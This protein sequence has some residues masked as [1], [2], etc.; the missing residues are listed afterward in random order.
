MKLNKVGLGSV[1][2]ALVSLVQN[3]NQLL[4]V[5]ANFFIPF[6]RSKISKRIQPLPFSF[7]KKYW[8]QPLFLT[9]PSLAIHESVYDEITVVKSA[10]SYLDHQRET[11]DQPIVLS[12]ND[13]SDLEEAARSTIE[14]KIA[15]Y[16]NYEPEKDNSDDRGEVKSLAHIATKGYLYFCSHDSNAIKLIEKAEDWDTNLEEVSAIRTYEIL[17][18]LHKSNPDLKEKIRAMY[19]YLYF[20]TDSDKKVNPNWGDFIKGMDALYNNIIENCP[21]FPII[22]TI[23]T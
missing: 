17:Y 21:D 19:K 11:Y 22:T 10:K 9:F 14:S 13:F 7:F 3:F 12:D 5:D 1:N 23:N 8:I 20:A 15:K 2:P 16:T 4:P 18:Y 6:D